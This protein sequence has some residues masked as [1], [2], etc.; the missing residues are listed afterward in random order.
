MCTAVFNADPALKNSNF[1]RHLKGGVRLDTFFS[2]VPIIKI[3]MWSYII[4]IGLELPTGIAGYQKTIR[5]YQGYVEN[6]EI[7]PLRF[8]EL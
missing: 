5:I 8:C 3:D 7:L 4:G 6:V 2:E 1:R